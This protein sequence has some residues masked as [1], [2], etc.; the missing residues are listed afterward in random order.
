MIFVTLNK[1]Y[2]RLNKIAFPDLY[3]F[4]KNERMETRRIN[5]A[6]CIM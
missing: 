3:F 1:T 4:H 6:Q 5:E 2:I